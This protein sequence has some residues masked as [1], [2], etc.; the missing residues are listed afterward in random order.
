MKII[1][2]DV[3][4]SAAIFFSSFISKCEITLDN[5]LEPSEAEV[6]RSRGGVLIVLESGTASQVNA[7][8]WLFFYLGATAVLKVRYGKSVEV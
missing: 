1:D 4:H 3:N 8:Q 5:G 6:R 2:S 7:T